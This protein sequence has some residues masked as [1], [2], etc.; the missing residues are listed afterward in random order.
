MFSAAD[1]AMRLEGISDATR[2]RVRMRLLYGDA[3]APQV[4]GEIKFCTQD[5]RR[6]CDPGC[7]RGPLHCEKW[8]C[9]RQQPEGHDPAACDE[10][11]RQRPASDDELAAEREDWLRGVCRTLDT[12]GQRQQLRADLLA[13]CGIAGEPAREQGATRLLAELGPDPEWLE[14]D[15][16]EQ[17]RRLRDGVEAV[18]STAAQQLPGILEALLNRP[19]LPG[20]TGPR[21]CHRTAAGIMVHVKPWCH[22]KRGS[23]K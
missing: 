17:R 6:C 19:D 12:P 2:R 13:A 11:W 4:Q 8:H 1:E 22:C 18:A 23:G 3:G 21:E 14:D 7:E 10:H 16:A 9:P 5:E 20:S 15:R